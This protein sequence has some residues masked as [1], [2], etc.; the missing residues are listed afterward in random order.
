MVG[1]SV[2]CD[3]VS[4]PAPLGS[5]RRIERHREA[6]WGCAMTT[7]AREYT[8]DDRRLMQDA[9]QY[10]ARQEPSTVQNERTNVGAAL[11]AAGEPVETWIEFCESADPGGTPYRKDC[12]QE[13]DRFG[14]VPVTGPGPALRHSWGIRLAAA[15]GT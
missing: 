11:K 8:S 3:S 5:S 10:I 7:P 4:T 2:T 13:W 15:T 14:E 12:L 9:M 1:D 6:D